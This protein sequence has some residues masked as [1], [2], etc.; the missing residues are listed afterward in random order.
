[1][2]QVPASSPGTLAVV[3]F[4]HQ[5]R[6]PEQEKRA[7]WGKGKGHVYPSSFP[8]SCYGHSDGGV[9]LDHFQDR[10]EWI[11]V[12]HILY[13]QQL[14]EMPLQLH[15]E[16]LCFGHSQPGS[17]A[18]RGESRAALGLAVWLFPSILVP[19]PAWLRSSAMGPAGSAWQCPAVEVGLRAASPCAPGGRG[20][21]LSAGVGRL[22][23]VLQAGEGSK[24]AGGEAVPWSWRLL[25]LEGAWGPAWHGGAGCSCSSFVQALS[26]GWAG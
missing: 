10:P 4:L 3:V 21:G 24:A 17:C 5:A 7:T 25:W 12:L 19:C 6:I 16:S 13:C 14:M 15:G 23:W 26:P 1:M 20:P 11:T 8:G 18:R 2:L 22:S 9:C